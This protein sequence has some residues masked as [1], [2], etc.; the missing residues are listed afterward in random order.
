MIFILIL[1]LQVRQIYGNIACAYNLFSSQARLHFHTDILLLRF[2]IEVWILLQPVQYF[3]FFTRFPKSN[4][5]PLILKW[6]D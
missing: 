3:V 2:Y 5:V 1:H 4:N 6:Y